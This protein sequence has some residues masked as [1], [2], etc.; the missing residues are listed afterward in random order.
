MG[1]GRRGNRRNR[2][3]RRNSD[4]PS[5]I[6]SHNSPRL[7]D[8][9][10]DLLMYGLEHG[11]PST[12]N[13]RR[14]K[15]HNNNKNKGGQNSS[16]R[17]SNDHKPNSLMENPFQQSSFETPIL[18]EGQGP[19]PQQQRNQKPRPR[20]RNRRIPQHNHDSNYHHGSQ[21]CSPG[22]LYSAISTLSDALHSHKH[23]HNY[24]HKDCNIPFPLLPTPPSS[25]A[26][27]T[28]F[29]PECSAVRRANITLRDWLLSAI[30]R[31]TEVIDSWSDE[32]GVSRGSADEMDWQ[33]EPV[34]RVLVLTTK[35]GEVGGREPQ[36][37]RFGTAKGGTLTM[38]GFGSC[39]GDY[40][41]GEDDYDRS[42]DTAAAALEADCRT[43]GMRTGRGLSPGASKLDLVTGLWGGSGS[44]KAGVFGAGSFL[45][46][47]DGGQGRI[48]AG[49][50]WSDSDPEQQLVGMASRSESPESLWY[51]F[52]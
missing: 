10:D 30:S 51:A 14:G 42:G 24:N 19:R 4:D 52:P 47:H 22:R 48:N 3:S 2:S 41:N 34:I 18:Q 6:I 15:R 36:R 27:L 21:G 9:D 23:K 26:R 7:L 49:G 31:A 46:T 43:A 38:G 25:P 37:E 29:C 11:Y 17:S 35:A 1:R 44:D 8:R 12:A 33:P 40:G 50:T 5:Q 20:N 28:R 39:P 16:G 32:V 45:G 13:P